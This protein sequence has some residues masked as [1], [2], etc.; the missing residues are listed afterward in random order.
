M[1]ALVREGMAAGAFGFSTSQFPGDVDGDGN[2]VPSR[3]ATTEEILELGSTLSEFSIG[4]IGI[5]TEN[6]VSGLDQ[7]TPAEENLMTALSVLSGRPV[8]WNS[9]RHT[10]DRPNAWRNHLRFMERAAE[11]GAQV[12]SVAK[13]HPLDRVFSLRTPTVFDG[14]PKWKE[15]LAQPHPIKM[16][17]LRNPDVRNVLRTEAMARDAAAPI[18]NRLERAVFL[19]SKSGQHAQFHNMALSKIGL[20]T[21]GDAIEVLLRWSV[22]EDLQADFAMVGVQNGDLD[23]VGQFIQSPFAVPGISD[24]GAHTDRQSNLYY[25]AYMLGHWVRDA[26][27]MSIEEAV[28]RLTF[29]PAVLYGIR[30]RGLLQTGMA[31][32]VVIFDLPKIGWSDPEWI[33]DFPGGEGRVVNHARGIDYVIVNGKIVFQD[34]RPSGE[35]PGRLLRSSAHM[36]RGDGVP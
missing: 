25:T 9:L 8:N 21:G 32:D 36:Q 15:V 2:P 29:V 19:R 31:A 11:A 30:D 28:R 27:R 10:W 7:F 24:A 23:A 18:W 34:G 12:Y 14:W 33:Y 20:Q 16:G 17:L 5:I 13:V 22:D 35:L 1:K 26:R 4:S 3:L 6:A